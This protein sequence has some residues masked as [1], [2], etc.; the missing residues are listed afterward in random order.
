MRARV[1]IKEA[2]LKFRFVRLLTNL[3]HEVSSD[4]IWLRESP[5][6]SGMRR[7]PAFSFFVVAFGAVTARLSFRPRPRPRKQPLSIL[8]I[9]AA[10]VQADGRCTIAVL[11]QSK[12]VIRGNFNSFSA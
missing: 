5:H 11:F 7:G 9:V 3:R 12:K 2:K 8:A 1:S 6:G 4:Q 10:N